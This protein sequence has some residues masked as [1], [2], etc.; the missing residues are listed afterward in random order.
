M[1]AFRLQ[2]NLNLLSEKVEKFGVFKD[3][4]KNNFILT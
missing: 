4:Q 3:Y 1:S 2:E